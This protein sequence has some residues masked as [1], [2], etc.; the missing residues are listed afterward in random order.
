MIVL[1]HS[2][3]RETSEPVLRY[4]RVDRARSCLERPFNAGH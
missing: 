3:V 4:M 2:I 1:S